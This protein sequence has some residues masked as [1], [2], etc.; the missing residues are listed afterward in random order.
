MKWP[1]YH[2]LAWDGLVGCKISTS[3]Q[4]KKTS[5]HMYVGVFFW[6]KKNSNK[7]LF[8]NPKPTKMNVQLWFDMRWSVRMQN[9]N[10]S[11]CQGKKM[12]R[13]KKKLQS[14]PKSPKWPSCYHS[15]AW[16]K[17]GKMQNVNKFLQEQKMS[18]KYFNQHENHRSDRCN[19]A[20][21]KTEW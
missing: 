16:D 2:S 13:D 8:I 1:S 17:S 10:M 19:K 15:L 11:K 12:T 9:F 7:I 18:K 14:A 21:H 20:Q 6:D 5:Y 3:W 4:R